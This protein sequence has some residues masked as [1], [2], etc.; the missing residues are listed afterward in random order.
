MK[1]IGIV[2]TRRRNTPQ[3][4]E[5]CRDVFLSIYEEGDTLVSG[6]CTRGGDLFCELFARQYG[7]PIKVYKADWDRMGPGAGFLRNTDI[8]KDADILIAVVAADRT[9]G[10]EDTIRKVEKMGKRVILVGQ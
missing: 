5:L 6:G 3:D 4:M 2:G 1:V 9:G 7:I 8:A 10:T